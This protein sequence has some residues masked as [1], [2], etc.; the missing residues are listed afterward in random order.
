MGAGAMLVGI[1]WRVGGGLPPAVLMATDALLMALSTFVGSA[2]GSLPWLHLALLFI[3]S[4]ASGLIVAVGRRGAVIGTQAVIGLVVFG[5]FSQP[6]PSTLGLAK[7]A[8]I[9][10]NV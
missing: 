3:W 7:R 5:R 6:I 2:T 1:A 9:R 8:Q 4:L 10:A